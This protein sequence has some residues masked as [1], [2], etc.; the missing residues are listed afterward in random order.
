MSVNDI[1]TL[2]DAE[3][4]ASPANS[5]STS[6]RPI[7]IQTLLDDES[8][9]IIDSASYCPQFAK[10]KKYEIADDQ[11]KDIDDD[12][13]KQ[14]DY[15]L[16]KLTPCSYMV[17]CHIILKKPKDL[18]ISSDAT[19]N[20][21]MCCHPRHW[22]S[23]K[24]GYLWYP[25]TIRENGPPV[26]LDAKGDSLQTNNK[27]SAK[28]EM[29]E[30]TLLKYF[31]TEVPDNN[32]GVKTFTY[33]QN[34]DATKIRTTAKCRGGLNTSRNSSQLQL[35]TLPASRRSTV[36]VV[37]QKYRLK[38][39]LKDFYKLSFRMSAFTSAINSLFFHI[40]ATLYY[41]NNLICP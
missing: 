34:F 2:T 40:A 15:S 9:D 31:I 10:Q 22:V 6:G 19:A 13:L 41:M 16:A 21:R 36:I 8:C 32:V 23:L 27:F 20:K 1:A 30:D 14:P 24:R 25:S 26:F 12:D 7:N 17:T 18:I 29:D 35:A 33:I 39:V 4:G 3:T 28:P 38:A 37:W 5:I 11:V